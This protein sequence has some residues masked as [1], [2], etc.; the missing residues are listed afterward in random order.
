V[1]PFK[2]TLNGVVDATA[3]LDKA[4]EEISKK[5]QDPLGQREFD[6]SRK[7]GSLC[8]VDQC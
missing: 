2:D 5:L 1:L 7:V 4:S 8:F 3:L 6:E